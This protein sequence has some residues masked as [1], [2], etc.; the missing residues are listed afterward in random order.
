LNRDNRKEKLGK[1]ASEYGHLKLL[2]GWAVYF[3]LFYLTERLIPAEHCR[4]VHMWLDDLIPFCEW[5]VIPYVL[6]YGM[7]VFSLGYFAFHNT[8]SFRCLQSYFIIT[9]MLAMVVYI[10][11]PTRQDLRPDIFPRDN[12]LTD[13]VRILYCVDTNTNV[14][15]SLH[16]ALSVAM[17]SVWGRERRIGSA[18][19][20]CIIFAC[21]LVCLSTMFIKQHSAVDFFAAI[22]VCL[23][24][25]WI[26]Y[27]K[28]DRNRKNSTK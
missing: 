4:S 26:V 24:A 9:Q 12:V 19:K 13:L 10:F 3:A 7:L 11:F 23:V 28:Y 20:V 27:G 15:P 5:F 22:P 16:V 14:C 21:V 17:A 25:E 2:Y 1:A 18:Y 8:G 6:W